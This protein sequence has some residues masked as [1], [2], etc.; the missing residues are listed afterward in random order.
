M[1][2]EGLWLYCD[3]TAWKWVCYRCRCDGMISTTHPTRADEIICPTKPQ[4]V[5]WP[6]DGKGECA[7]YILKMLQDGLCDG[8]VCQGRSGALLGCFFCGEGN[9]TWK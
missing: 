1:K 3:G 4:P 9:A 8:R 2:E 5:Q 6:L 7:V